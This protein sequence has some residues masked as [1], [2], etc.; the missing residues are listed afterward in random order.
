[1]I[2][3]EAIAA[4]PLVC[5]EV[6]IHGNMTS[7]QVQKTELASFLKLNFRDLRVVDPSFRNESPV[8]LARKNVVVGIPR[9][10]C[11]VLLIG[12]GYLK[13]VHFEH[14]RAVIQATSILL[15]DPPHPSVQNFI[16]SLR[17]RIRDRS[18]PLPFEFR[19]LEAILIDVCTSLSR[20]LRTLV[21]AVENV[22]DTLSSNDTGADTVRSC[23]DRLLPLQNSL[24]EFE[25]KIREA[26]TALND[27]LR[28]DEDMSEM[29]LTTKLETG[30]RRRVDQH[31]EVEMMFET[32]LKQ[33][34]SMLN[35][36]ASTIQTVRVTENITQIRLD[37]MRNRILRLE[38]YLNL[39]MLSLSTG[40]WRENFMLVCNYHG[41][42]HFAPRKSF[43]VLCVCFF[44]CSC[45]DSFE[46]NISIG[47]VLFGLEYWPRWETVILDESRLTFFWGAKLVTALEVH[48]SFAMQFLRKLNVKVSRSKTPPTPAPT[49]A[50]IREHIEL[51]ERKQQVWQKKVDAEQQKAKTLLMKKDRRGALMALKR[52]KILEKEIANTENVR[53]NLELQALTLE[54]AN[55]S[56]Q[57]VDAFRKG[58]KQLRKAHEKLKVEEV[59]DVMADTQELVEESNMISEA[60]AQPLSG[61]TYLD[62]DELGAELDELEGEA[63]DRY[64]LETEEKIGQEERTT[65]NL[66]VPSAVKGKTVKET[67][68][69]RVEVPKEEEEEEVNDEERELRELERSMA[70]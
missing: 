18:H 7:K 53:Y 69:S 11:P 44:G 38:V 36:V 67:V 55:A 64:M 48:F 41:Q 60:L 10:F 26:H 22:L 58:N 28:S 13:V 12:F 25:V 14:I 33:I 19:S 16:P 56:A 34:D 62:E 49:I 30:H 63:L 32:Y 43:R 20:Q 50:D 51:L 4:V 3:N 61:N 39:G 46:E 47:V 27:V 9:F 68:S 8:F 52:K 54:N 23:L 31:E 21:P 42:V 24:N 1:M 15:F 17:T 70:M 57:T 40:K 6:D 59:D 35:E 66:R 45:L 5:I 37:A 2:R 29:Y 65:G